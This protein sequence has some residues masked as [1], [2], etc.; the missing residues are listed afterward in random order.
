[1]KEIN[2]TWIFE[3]KYYHLW[4]SCLTIL[5][6]ILISTWLTRFPEGNY[7]LSNIIF[8]IILLTFLLKKSTYRDKF[9]DYIFPD[10]N[11]F[12]YIIFVI[13]IMLLSITILKISFLLFRF[14]EY[15][16]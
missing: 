12:K 5:N 13:F 14:I 15:I 9:I 1:M 4:L 11:K 6:P 8:T 16:A 7:W 10:K 3:K 2:I